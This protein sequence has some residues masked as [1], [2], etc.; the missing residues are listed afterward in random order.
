MCQKLFWLNI[1]LRHRNRIIS[2][3][4]KAILQPLKLLVLMSFVLYLRNVFKKSSKLMHNYPFLPQLLLKLSFVQQ[5][6]VENKCIMG[7]HVIDETKL[8][9]IR[10][11]KNDWFV[12]VF[13]LC[14]LEYTVIKIW[15]VRILWYCSL[16]TEKIYN[17]SHIEQ[18]IRQRVFSCNQI[19]VKSLRFSIQNY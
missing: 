13:W 14:T 8:K 2:L 12:S 5:R 16:S 10:Y 11:F 18:L 17:A 1:A 7:I 15:N 3:H 4:L 6:M 19:N 9:L